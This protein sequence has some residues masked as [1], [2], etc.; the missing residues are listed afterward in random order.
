MPLPAK[1]FQLWLQSVAPA[2]STADICRI[3]GIKR[4]GQWSVPARLRV[5]S[6]LG[7]V[8]LDFSRAENPRLDAAHRI[9][10]PTIEPEVCEASRLWIVRWTT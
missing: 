8:L 4:T 7:T 1:A 6:V 5:Q 2:A 9:S 10:Q 3:S